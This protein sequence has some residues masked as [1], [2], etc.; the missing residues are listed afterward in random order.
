MFGEVSAVL[1]CRSDV[2]TVCKNYCK[3]GIL[4]STDY[5]AIVYMYPSL[6][7]KMMK[8]I[9]THLTNPVNSFFMNHYDRISIFKN[10]TK[11]NARELSFHC[12]LTKIL[13]G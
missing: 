12:F 4:S 9:K 6:F 13:D 11:K 3:I 10:L 8:Q 7:K 5:E 2:T 1:G